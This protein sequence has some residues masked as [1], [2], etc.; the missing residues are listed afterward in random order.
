MLGLPRA[1]SISLSSQ[2]I[3]TRCNLLPALVTSK[4]YR[5]LEF[6]AVGSWWVYVKERSTREDNGDSSISPSQESIGKL[7]R[8]P[9]GREDVFADKSVDI[10]SKRSLMKLLKLAADP[11]VHIPFL[12]TWGFLPFHHVLE[13]HFKIPPELQPPIFALTS[14]PYPPSRTNTHTA[15]TRIHRH[16]TSI[17][18]FGPGFGSV[19]PKWGGLSEISQVA[20]RAGA[21][22]GG[23]YVLKQGI[24]SID[25]EH[26]APENPLNVCLQGGNDIKT[27]WVV[28]TQHDL[29]GQN[30]EATSSRVMKVSRSITIVS[31]SLPA[32]FPLP[33][34]GAPP[35][36]GAVIIFPT[37][38]LDAAPGSRLDDTPVYLIV[39]SS[40]TG[41]CPSGQSK[42]QVHS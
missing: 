23:V 22:G 37:G 3:Y 30:Q 25:V 21:V 6:M 14:S 40:D 5:Q 29:P 41:E 4:V 28:G 7:S 26:H 27:S 18:L 39:H 1:Y 12:D 17:G 36:A 8:I 16:L 24:A 13:T 9:G 20:C 2:L 31:S 32:L 42:L 10:R 34:E 38:S 33:A 11:E 15:I 19:I 35:P